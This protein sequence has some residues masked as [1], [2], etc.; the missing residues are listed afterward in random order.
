VR[1][2]A[3]YRQQ[4]QQE[5]TVNLTSVTVDRLELYPQASLGVDNWMNTFLTAMANIPI[6]GYSRTYY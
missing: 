4:E 3:R 6:S 1:D 2:L 5:L